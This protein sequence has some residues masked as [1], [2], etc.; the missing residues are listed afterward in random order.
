MQHRCQTMLIWISLLTFLILPHASSFANVSTGHIAGVIQSP[1]GTPLAHANISIENTMLGTSS[2][3]T[4]RFSLKKVPLGEQRLSI[5]LVGYHPVSKTIQVSSASPPLTITMTSKSIDLPPIVVTGTRSVRDIENT[6]IQ[7]QVIT[8]E[9]ITASGV[10]RLSELL[11]NQTG[12]A[13]ISDHGSG[14]QM[15]GFDPDYTLILVNG[16]PI[17][18]RT[19]GT[20]DLDRFMVGNIEQIEI[21]KGSTSS[22]YG[23]E[24]LAGVINL[25]TR[26]PEKAFAASVHPRYGSFG[27]FNFSSDLETQKDKVG[28]SLFVD[29]NQNAGYD[30]TPD[31]A[32]PTAPEYV[33]YTFAPTVTYQANERTKL[34]IASRIFKEK[35]NSLDEITENRTVHPVDSDAKLTD[36]NIAPKISFQWTPTLHITGK[37]YTAHYHTTSTLTYQADGAVFSHAIF[38]QAYNKAEIQG[39]ILAGK[40]NII[41]MG[42]GGIWESVEAD[43]ISGGKQTSQSAFAFLQEEWLPTSWLDV[44]LSARID[45]HSDYA[46]RLSPK[47]S[48]LLKPFSWLN[49][50]GSVGSGFKAP[51]F[52]QL[53]LDFT[54]PSAGYSV[55]GSTFVREGM[56]RFEEEGR[57]AA[58]LQDVDSLEGIRAESAVSFNGGIEIIPNNYI[59]AKINFFRNNVQDLIE[60]SPIARKTNGQSVYSYFNLNRVF[61]EGYE[62]HL[63]LKPFS[64]ATVS[65]GYQYLEAKDKGVIEE[66]EDDKIVKIDPETQKLRHVELEEYGGLYNR[67]KHMTTVQLRYNSK[68]LGL[69]T[70]LRGTFR[71][72]Y[73]YR[74]RNLNTIL[75]AP[76]EF[77]PG[78]D[79]WHVSVSKDIPKV[80][81]LQAGINNIFNDKRIDY[82]SLP[83]RSL[84]AGLIKKF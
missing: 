26:P 28:I 29:R 59:T 21:V 12:L 54:N 64:G 75:D 79:I 68:A 35:Q 30:H 53:Y 5:N 82:T 70:S 16:E 65:I 19:A 84:Y 66:I 83:G 34:T 22:L 41:T 60:S 3:T 9:E 33:T 81:T 23:S 43:R 76:E 62:S 46:T 14:V 78:Y 71:G 73:G 17:I 72:Q 2:S 37:L 32:P 48:V 56:A 6:P 27:S 36:W 50:R 8:K 77:A 51:T 13:V 80:G 10:L 4:G 57:I 74:D 61:T 42:V 25:I 7:T 55:L 18:G 20:M 1:T 45:A 52:Q 49:L 31:T 69:T 11:E 39:Q 24:A 15:Q 67:S 58:V 44:V 63:T 38:Q 40:T 47:M